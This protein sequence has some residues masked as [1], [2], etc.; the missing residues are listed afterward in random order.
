MHIDNLYMPAQQEMPP[1]LKEKLGIKPENFFWSA[2]HN[3]NSGAPWAS[4]E[5]TA[6]IID[7]FTRAAEDAAKSMRPAAMLLGST[8]ARCN[9]NRAMKGPDGKFYGNLDHKYMNYLMD[10]RPTDTELGMLWFVDEKGRPIA[11]AVAYAG[12]AN[13]MCR[14]MP[15]CTG[16]WSGW[17][18]RLMEG[19]SGAVVMHING[20]EGDVD[21]RGIQ[22]SYDR[23]IRAGW[24]VATAA[25]RATQ[26]LEFI[27]PSALAGV[28]VRHGE[29]IGTPVKE[30]APEQKLGVNILTLGTVA[31]VDVGGEMWTQIGLELRKGS[32]YPHTYIDFK[33]G[34]YYPEEW[35]FEAKLYGTKDRRP[36]WG[37]AIRDKAI[38]MLKEVMGK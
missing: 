6:Q 4:K 7:G 25:A 38:R 32:P 15:W 12:H 33:S 16:D 9:F 13:M 21:M 10:S 14:I 34:Y 8:D 23:T 29:A 37:P 5:F 18:E 1:I 22:V 35:A 31:F 28:G 27:D 24:D 26:K 11:G 17:M 19:A 36:D 2:T 20:A 30:G 3:H